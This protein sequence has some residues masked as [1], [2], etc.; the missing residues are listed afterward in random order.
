MSD[1]ITI[2]L[3]KQGKH[4]GKYA[5][6]IDEIDNDLAEI[7]W[8][9]FIS[10]N[11]EYVSRTVRQDGNQRTEQL[12]RVVLARKLGRGLLATE[13]VD[14]ING[15]GLD[16]RRS[17][18][19]LATPIQNQQNSRKRTDNTSGCKGVHWRKDAGLWT[20]QIRING[21][22]Q[23]LGYFDTKE[24][25]R[26]AYNATALQYHQEFANLGE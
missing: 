4:K 2:P 19:R 25:A 22:L 23:F 20:A 12:H 3:S 26:D 17:N 18:L 11:T 24:A 5:A 9:V 14:H 13:I 6:I 1:F 7:N 16:N 21:S 15:N 8:R 10:T